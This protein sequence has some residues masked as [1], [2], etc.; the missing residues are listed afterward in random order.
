MPAGSRWKRGRRAERRASSADASSGGERQVVS[1]TKALDLH[2]PGVGPQTMS[3]L[4]LNATVATEK[5]DKILE[6]VCGSRGIRPSPFSRQGPS[7]AS[8]FRNSIGSLLWRWR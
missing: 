5:L 2:R 6:H 4:L 3:H 7:S 8:I 1:V